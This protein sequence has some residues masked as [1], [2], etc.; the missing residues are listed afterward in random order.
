MTAEGRSLLQGLSLFSAHLD[1]MLSLRCFEQPS[2][3]TIIVSVCMCCIP[4]C[5]QQGALAGC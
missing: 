2:S 4:V 3:P 5:M 1:F